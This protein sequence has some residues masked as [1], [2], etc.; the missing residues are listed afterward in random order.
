MNI[1]DKIIVENSCSFESFTQMAKNSKDLEIC[2][3]SKEL[4]EK[5][6][7]FGANENLMPANCA[8]VSSLI[9]EEKF[10]NYFAEQK[11][12]CVDMETSIV[13]SA[14]ALAKINAV[15]LLYV[16][17]IL[18]KTKF[19]EALSQKEKSSL[20]N[21]RKTISNLLITFIKND[22]R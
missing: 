21:S 9:L 15:A 10:L 20:S 6:L 14:A 18:G 2:K 8:T 16:T 19:C 5:V 17:D 11:I 4:L 12:S 3:P 13:F 22:A 1:G 7:S